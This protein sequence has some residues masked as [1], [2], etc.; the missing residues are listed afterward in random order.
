MRLSFSTANL[1]EPLKAKERAGKSAGWKGERE[2]ERER[3]IWRRE[4]RG[5]M[6]QRQRQRRQH[7]GGDGRR[8]GINRE[9]DRSDIRERRILRVSKIGCERSSRAPSSLSLAHCETGEKRRAAK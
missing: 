3:E 7:G 8:G 5:V 6:R 1:L 4:A 9:T 2:R